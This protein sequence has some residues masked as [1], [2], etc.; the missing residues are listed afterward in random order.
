MVIFGK[1]ERAWLYPV[2]PRTVSK[3]REALYPSGSKDDSK[4]ARLF[5]EILSKHREHLRRLDPDTKEMRL[6]Q[7]Q[8]ENRRK[9]VDERTARPSPKPLPSPPAD[10]RS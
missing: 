1:Y 4:D 8:V 7:F 9:L 10:S 5:L 6:L 2:H 3:F